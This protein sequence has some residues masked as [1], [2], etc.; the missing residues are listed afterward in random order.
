MDF[1]RLSLKPRILRAVR[2]ARNRRVVRLVTS[3]HACF[4]WTFAVTKRGKRQTHR[5][6]T[7]QTVDHRQT[8]QTVLT[9]LSRPKRLKRLATVQTGQTVTHRPKRVKRPLT[10]TNGLNGDRD[11]RSSFRG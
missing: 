1:K 8:D 5:K 9:V 7:G 6:Q 2:G 10:D 3:R 11:E 4:F